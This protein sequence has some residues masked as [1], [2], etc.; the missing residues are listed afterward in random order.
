MKVAILGA[1]GTAGTPAMEQARAQ[2]HETAPLSRSGGVDVVTGQGLRE[3]LAGVDAVI[4]A[5]MPPMGSEQEASRNLLEACEQ[6][7]VKRL[8]FLSI[9][10][11]ENPAFDAFD[12]YVAKRNQEDLIRRSS[13][14]YRI[15]KSAQWMEFAT[16]PAAVEF[17]DD[18]A[19]VADWLIQPVAVESV[20][21][22]LVTALDGGSE[23]LY[24]AGPE[25]IH[26]P[27]LTR[28]YLRATGDHRQVR[29]RPADLAA[30]ADGSLLAP[31]QTQIAGPTVAEWLAEVEKKND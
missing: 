13:L 29:S 28:G 7:Q 30:F 8:V 25:Q 22:A 11:V 16:N 5:T 23:D 15:V 24:I 9:A 12:Y 27:D 2:G 21:K 20:G 31:P 10:G 26:L 3:A 6:A 17:T 1:S 19:V 18:E 4:D 14:S